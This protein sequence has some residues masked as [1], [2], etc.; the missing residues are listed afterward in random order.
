M[1]IEP[2][3]S[4]QALNE[5]VT[6]ARQVDELAAEVASAS[7]EQTQGITQINT[8]VGQMD[9]V[10]QSNAASAEESA[11]AAE[12]LNAQAE[13]M[14]QVVGKLMQL[15]GQQPEPPGKPV[16]TNM[17]RSHSETSWEPA[18]DN[19]APQPSVDVGRGIITWDEARMATGVAS[20]DEQHQELIRLIN[21]LH[22]ACVAGTVTEN[23]M[24]QL[25]FLG[26]YA[27]N[28]FANEETIMEQHRCPAAG[29]NLAAHAKFLRDYEKLVA[30]AQAGGASSR[31][32]LQLKQMLADWL[33]SHICRVDTQLR[34]CQ[35]EPYHTSITKAQVRQ[36]DLPMPAD[37]SFYCTPIFFRN[38]SSERGRPRNFSIE[39]LMSR[40][41]PTA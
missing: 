4:P 7:R 16:S 24:Q 25:E 21:E 1:D 15:I 17:V 37:G 19:A 22:S 2:A 27:T 18:G 14:K 36:R 34:E 6:K 5:I 12:E 32:A 11:A 33:A 9:K 13:C 3:R 30:D 35:P 26:R 40:E 29:K 28:H 31:L 8:A 20:V 39:T 10:T 41:S 38:G 23:L